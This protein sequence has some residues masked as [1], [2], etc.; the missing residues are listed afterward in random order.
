MS[1]PFPSDSPSEHSSGRAP[2][3]C[4]TC[5]RQKRKCDKVLPSCGL[6]V[7]MRRHCD[8]TDAVPAPTPED[9]AALQ[10]KLVQLEARLNTN[11]SSS[12]ASL[13]GSP[14]PSLAPAFVQPDFSWQPPVPVQFPS[15]VFLDLSTWKRLRRAV[16]KPVVEIPEEVLAQLGETAEIQHAINEYFVTIHTWLPII[17]KSRMQNG[18]SLLEGG[19]DLAMLFLAVK[20]VTTIPLPSIAAADHYIYLSA[21]RFVL[22]LEHG[23]TPSIMV[24]QSMVLIAIYEYSH[25]I[26]PAAWTTIGA[27]ARYADFL[28][29]PNVQES[30]I[31][32]NNVV[33]HPDFP[34]YAAFVMDLNGIEQTTWVELEERRRTWWAIVVLDRIICLGNQKKCIL[35]DPPEHEILPANDRIWD[36]DHPSLA[37]QRTLISPFTG[38]PSP[39]ARLCEAAI[40]TSRV[41]TH[42]RSMPTSQTGSDQPLLANTAISL[43]DNLLHASSVVDG[44]ANASRQGY[45]LSAYHSDPFQ[46]TTNWNPYLAAQSVLLS[47]TLLL[48]ET[49]SWPPTYPPSSTQEA[50]LRHRAI[51]GLQTTSSQVMSLLNRDVFSQLLRPA[52]APPPTI[53]LGL[54]A[55]DTDDDLLDGSSSILNRVSP[56]IL[57]ALYS[58]TSSFAWAAQGEHSTGKEALT[59]AKQGLC[60]I[61][62]R[63]R[64]AGEY[65]KMLEQDWQGS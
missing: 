26:Y 23:G 61:N 31:L 30:S 20:L 58:A 11:S 13:G 47:A 63:W 55:G 46:T 38:D 49:Y 43:L 57:D 16:P 42:V 1:L 19:S 18:H 22:S 36:D 65:L 21:K 24:L 39:F 17:S 62:R 59:I 5:K 51:R 44:E 27:C 48:Q 12:A 10:M 28:G 15:S 37:T 54:G 14:P 7:R 53:H 35:P 6:C 56:L 40:L 52:S 50:N 64:V 33:R 2:Q 34:Q 29:L 60:R 45:S 41:L 8:Y 25:G 4:G 3:A 32:L 9:F